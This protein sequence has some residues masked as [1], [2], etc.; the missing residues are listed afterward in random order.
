M[1]IAMKNIGHNN[2]LEFQED[3]MYI[4]CSFLQTA[5][6]L[7]EA[8]EQGDQWKITAYSSETEQKM[9]KTRPQKEA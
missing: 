4:V 6:V 5:L 8:K 9:E 7:F 3:A 1:N 2:V